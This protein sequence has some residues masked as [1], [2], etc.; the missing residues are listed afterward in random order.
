MPKRV[1]L[2]L[3]DTA[4]AMIEQHAGDRTRGE[5]VSSVIETWQTARAVDGA[6]A[7]ERVEARLS[8]L[9]D[10]IRELARRGD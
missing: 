1:A 7:L 9:E 8:R 3:S 2:V 10:A 6:G 4:L 5:W